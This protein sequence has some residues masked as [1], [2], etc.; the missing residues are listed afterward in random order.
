MYTN[1]C[2][3]LIVNNNSKPQIHII[4]KILNRSHKILHEIKITVNHFEIKKALEMLKNDHLFVSIFFLK[5]NIIF[6]L[7]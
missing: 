7:N 5:R 2:N 3:K 6:D 1:Y 4:I